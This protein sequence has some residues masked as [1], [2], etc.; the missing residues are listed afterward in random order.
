MPLSNNRRVWVWAG[1]LASHLMFA[2]AADGQSVSFIARQDFAADSQ[3]AS[4]A[5]GDFN[6]DGI[7]DLA[8]ANSYSN[9]VSVLLGNG[10]GT[11][12]T[13]RNFGAGSF[14]TYVAV[15][16][17]N[18]DGVP[19]L[20]VTNAGTPPDYSNDV[21]VLL[22]N[23]DGT[24]QTA[25]NFGAGSFSTYVAVGDLNGDGVPDL[26]VANAGMYPDYA[27][28][29]SV[30]LGSGDGSFQ[31]AQSLSASDRPRSV[32][33]GDFNGDGKLDLAVA[34]G[35]VSVLLGNGDGTFQAA[36]HFGPGGSSVALGDFNG[37]EKLDLAV[38]YP[39]TVPHY[40]GS[41]SV[42]LGNG[43]GSFQEPQRVAGGISPLSVAVGDFNG[44]GALD[45]AVANDFS[46][47]GTG[48]FVSV[49]LGNGDG[50]FRAAPSFVAGGILAS[51]AVGDFNGDG[52]LD[53][54]VAD[55]AGV[56][57]LM[58]N[59]DGRFQATPSFDAGFQPHSVVVGDFNGDGALDLAVANLGQRGVAVLLG[60]G[61]GSFQVMQS[62]AAG[63]L[64]VVVAVG[65]FNGDGA[66]DL[67]VADS[68]FPNSTVSVLLG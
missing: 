45:V 33:V 23:G 18:G 57:V 61:D 16:D 55:S 46:S 66:L 37:D 25:R 3:P 6:A 32:A 19:D 28:S 68:I 5:V 49:L 30:L 53:L 34:G 1:V 2:A 60:N 40:F 54:A 41:V 17:F 11:F 56:S 35:F 26:V 48:G 43:D 7:P 63:S 52:A 51:V 22:G 15:G 29:V 62:F 65:D 59:G 50:S 24:F 14:P 13:A 9:D 38:A 42:L 47:P 44:D 58:G 21:S 67:A 4:V 10:D 27:G 20:V 36:V 8:V 31:T 64:A 39:G 12:Q